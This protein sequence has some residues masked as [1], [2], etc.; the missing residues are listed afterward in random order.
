[1][2]HLSRWKQR[3]SY[4]NFKWPNGGW[5]AT[6]IGTLVAISVFL[7]PETARLQLAS[8]C[9]IAIGVVLLPT[10]LILSTYAGRVVVVFCRRA[11]CYY[12][13][14]GH[15]GELEQNL[16]S[17]HVFTRS[18]LEDRQ[19]L[20]AFQIACCYVYDTRTFITLK[21]KPGARVADG[22][23]VVVV[24]AR[25]GSVLGRFVAS[26]EEDGQYR[27]ELTGF[28]D[29]LWLGYVKQDVGHK[30]LPPPEAVAVVMPITTGDEDE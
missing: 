16:D 23:N 22:D 19:G 1:M 4:P 24:D 2:E 17:S 30:T 3:C 29:P 28:M 20:N 26:G 18:L 12:G 8:R 13:L 10:L 5:W 9:G 14:L 6:I 21:K 11:R 7:F 27:C 25:E 15:I